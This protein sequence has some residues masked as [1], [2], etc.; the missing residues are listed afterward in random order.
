M[1]AE[2]Y[3]R[4]GGQSQGSATGLTWWYDETRDPGVAYPIQE[5]ITFPREKLWTYSKITANA[6]TSKI[7][8]KKMMR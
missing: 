3:I 2:G 7:K 1:V 5:T 4:L 8:L 6:I